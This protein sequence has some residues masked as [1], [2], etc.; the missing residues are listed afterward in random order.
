MKKQFIMR[1]NWYNE[2]SQGNYNVKANTLQTSKS[3]HRNYY[4]MKL[5]ID[6]RHIRQLL[7]AVYLQGGI[8]SLESNSFSVGK[9]GLRYYNCSFYSRLR[10][11][12]LFVLP[13]QE[14]GY[15]VKT[16]CGQRKVDIEGTN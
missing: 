14:I 9:G 10:D 5:N 16:V 4:T 13:K 2:S 8:T 12:C 11:S 15:T 3:V 6:S 7:K 1:I